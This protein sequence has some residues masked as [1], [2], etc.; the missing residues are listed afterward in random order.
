MQAN[1]S[2][3]QC[4][5]FSSEET[6]RREQPANGDRGRQPLKGKGELLS[7]NTA[8]FSVQEENTTTGREARPP[9][10]REGK[11]EQE[12][13]RMRTAP[14]KREKTA[15]RLPKERRS[16]VLIFSF[17]SKETE[18][19]K[20]TR[21]GKRGKTA[22]QGRE[23]RHH[24]PNERASLIA[25]EEEKPYVY[26]SSLFLFQMSISLHSILFGWPELEVY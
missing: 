23:G 26:K 2:R 13:R 15:S 8:C 10:R 11:E 1:T 24:H 14:P 18:K 22:T 5:R 21:Q 6:K 7:Y 25:Q 4:R 16:L 12:G 19:E 3:F 17:S 20:T 9:S